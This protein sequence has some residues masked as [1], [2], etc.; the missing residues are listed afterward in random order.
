MDCPKVLPR[1]Y[2]NPNSI[3]IRIN[4]LFGNEINFL[5]LRIHERE[6][7]Q[8][9]RLMQRLLLDINIL[10]VFVNRLMFSSTKET[11]H[12]SV[13]SSCHIVLVVGGKCLH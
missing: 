7:K 4:I 6:A 12:K 2:S 1:E 8:S 11:L 13:G 9:V 10:K 3:L 5:L